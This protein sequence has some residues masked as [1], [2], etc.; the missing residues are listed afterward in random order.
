[1]AAA[2]AR[3]AVFAKAPEPG[4]VKTRLIPALGAAAA[5]EL[6]RR[7]IERTLEA[8]LAAGIGPV[9]LW[10]SPDASHPFFL[11]CAR[12]YA[13]ALAVQGGVDLGER[14]Q[15]ALDAL[16]GAGERA[17]LIGSDI[18]ALTPQYLREADSALAAGC[19]AVLG[20]AEDGGYVLIGLRRSAPSLFAGMR[21][22]GSDVCEQ[23]RARLAQVGM[24]YRELAVLWDVDRPEDL[25]RLE[26]MKNWGQ[27]DI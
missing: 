6:Q 3:V 18:P 16:L 2:S 25:P 13:I 24:R 7:L 4:E 22:G 11:D 20:P 5:A 17:L 23:T 9:E 10:C 15:L 8:A 1:M 26:A 19:D 12:R 27:S 21:W 14:M